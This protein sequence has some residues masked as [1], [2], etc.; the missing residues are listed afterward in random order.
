MVYSVDDNTNDLSKIPYDDLNKIKTF[1]ELT[2]FLLNSTNKKYI[3][4]VPNLLNILQDGIDTNERNLLAVK[5][6][7]EILKHEVDEFIVKYN[8][9]MDSI[10][11]IIE[12]DVS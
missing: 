12:S 9:D 10:T 2:E 5:N 6:D 4:F 8:E 3:L 11:T 7:Y 1:K